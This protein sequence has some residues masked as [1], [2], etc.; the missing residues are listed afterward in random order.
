MKIPYTA[1]PPLQSHIDFPASF[2][3]DPHLAIAQHF[4]TNGYGMDHV[5]ISPGPVIRHYDCRLLLWYLI[6]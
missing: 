1:H 6:A 5:K 4:L 2:L 3:I